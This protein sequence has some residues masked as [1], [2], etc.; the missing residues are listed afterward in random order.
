VVFLGRVEAFEEADRVPLVF[1]S[2]RYA[3]PHYALPAD[4][5]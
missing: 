4:T 2:G 3:Q 1:H 5:R